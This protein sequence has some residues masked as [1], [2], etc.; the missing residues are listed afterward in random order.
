MVL[1]TGMSAYSRVPSIYITSDIRKWC[2]YFISSNFASII[3]RFYRVD[4][5]SRLQS[6][7]VIAR[8]RPS[9][10][11]NNLFTVGKAYQLSCG[12]E[13]YSTGLL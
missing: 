10:S 4:R 2:G 1:D 6:A 9:H 3:W 13:K 5:V 7:E 8:V 12:A 11:T